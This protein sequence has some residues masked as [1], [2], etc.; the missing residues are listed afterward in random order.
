VVVRYATVGRLSGV[1]EDQWGLVTRRQAELAGVSRATLQRLA[2]EGVLERVAYGVYQVAGAP[3]P[4]DRALKA[5]WLQL[6][7][8]TPAWDRTPEQGVVSHRS[9]AAAYGLSHLPADRHDFTLPARR[10]SRRPD[11]RLHQRPLRSGEWG[12]RHGLPVTRPARIAADLVDDKEDPEAV[13][14]VVADALRAGH[15]SPGAF[16]DALARHAARFGLRR[17][18]GLALLGRLLDLVGDR[19]TPR[20]MQ[21]ARAHVA[22]AAAAGSE[23]DLVPAHAVERRG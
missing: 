5:A 3:M 21:E 17:G 19:D 12:S 18:D 9:A 13:A 15:E 7:P 10:Q 23:P 11:V 8:E 1:A 22:G 4:A 2:S 14:H 20:W 16:V 6:A